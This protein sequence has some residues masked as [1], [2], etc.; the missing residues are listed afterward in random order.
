VGNLRWE[1]KSCRAL[2]TGIGLPDCKVKW[3]LYRGDG[4]QSQKYLVSIT[5]PKRSLIPDL[6]EWERGWTWDMQNAENPH[7]VSDCEFQWE[8]SLWPWLSPATFSCVGLGTSRRVT[9]GCGLARGG[10]T[11]R[12]KQVTGSSL[13]GGAYKDWPQDLSWGK[14]FE[15]KRW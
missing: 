10:G 11:V 8:R 15:D 14:G 1:K 3:L 5:S 13:K 2:G 12:A 9:T 6:G 7:R 4:L